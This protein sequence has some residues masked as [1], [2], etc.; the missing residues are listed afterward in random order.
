MAAT[1]YRLLLIVL[2]IA[3][4]EG[5]G[6]GT[7]RG[8]TPARTKLVFG[9]QRST[10]LIAEAGHAMDGKPYDFEWATFATPSVLFEAFRSGAVDVASS[11]DITI[12]NA[13]AAGTSMK[14]VGA[15]HG[16][17]WLKG[18][19]IIV[20][21]GSSVRTVTDLKGRHVVV[22][23]AR[24]GSGDNLLR[25]AL[26]EVG[27]T[28]DD[29]TVSYAPF[30]DSLSAFQSNAL[31][32]LVTNDPHLIL[33]EQHGGRIIRNGE[34]LNSGLGLIV[35]SDAALAD[36]AKRAIIGNVLARLNKASRWCLD[37]PDSYAEVFAQ[38]TGV[39]PALAKLVVARGGSTIDP[40]D[41]TVIATEQR[42]ANDLVERGFWQKH[43]DI[44]PAFD[45]TAFV[46]TVKL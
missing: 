6:G 37:H 28:A 32:I 43:L 27:L 12:L 24:G 17:A 16:T 15:I 34:G 36:P 40:I 45:S 26:R 46:G 13:V 1:M 23:S 39:D 31:D 11:N 42:L 5:C 22:S 20:Q 14:I 29:V 9:E 21:G 25:G 3:T 38:R 7:E 33:A 35:A 18:V 41:A 44:S 2:L 10:Q 8:A 4:C 30:S 19:G